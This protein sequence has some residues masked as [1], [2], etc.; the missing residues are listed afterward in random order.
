MKLF[1]VVDFLF[2]VPKVSV[3]LRMGKPGR[4]STHVDTSVRPTT[5]P[6]TNPSRSYTTSHS[7]NTSP[8]AKLQYRYSTTS[9][10]YNTS[11]QILSTAQH[12]Y[13]T[14]FLHTYSLESRSISSIATALDTTVRLTT[15]CTVE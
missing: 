8:T 1:G 4:R 11:L 3:R 14:M 7:H 15:I 9:Q 5:I 12:Y 2:G 10:P 6:L 13:N